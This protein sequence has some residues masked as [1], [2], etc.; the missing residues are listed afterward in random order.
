MLQIALIAGLLAL[1]MLVVVT[2]A[3]AER[4]YRRL[5]ELPALTSP[6]DPLSARR[7][8]ERTANESSLPSVDIV[9]P[10]RNESAVIGRVVTSLA[11]LD[12]PAFRLTVNDDAS[13]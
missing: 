6:L 1:L 10:A 13:T 2:A 4:N 11:A 7:E 3:L 8:G 12:Y 9:V 5:P